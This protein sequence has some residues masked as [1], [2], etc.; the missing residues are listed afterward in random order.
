MHIL[1][2]SPPNKSE[3]VRANPYFSGLDDKILIENSRGMDLRAYES[4]EIIFWEMS[5][6]C[7]AFMPSWVCEA[8]QDFTT[9]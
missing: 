2:V 7:D 9:E 1:P 8:V 5:H 3:A 4:G 6:I